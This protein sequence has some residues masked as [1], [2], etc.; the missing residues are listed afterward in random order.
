MV[1]SI[2]GADGEDA[3]SRGTSVWERDSLGCDAVRDC[4]PLVQVGY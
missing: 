1:H 3:E 2:G 4:L